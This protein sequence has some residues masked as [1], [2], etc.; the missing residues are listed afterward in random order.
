MKKTPESITRGIVAALGVLILAGT[1]ALLL[2]TV[3]SDFPFIE[4]AAGAA[5]MLVCGLFCAFLL[6]C[7]KTGVWLA[8]ILVIAFWKRLSFILLVDTAPVSDFSV[9]YDAALSAAQGDFSI[10]A[11]GRGYFWAYGY[12]IPF[13]LYEALVLRLTG[14]VFA[15]KLLNVIFMTGSCLLVY[16]LAECAGRNAALCAAFLYAVY[17]DAI[18]LSSVLTNQHIAL[19]F[20]LLGL[21]LFCREGILSAVFAGICLS[22]S[23]LMRPGAV[24]GLAAVICLSVYRIIR[25]LRKGG[26]L[27]ALLR[28][29]AAAGVY[30]ALNAAAGAILTG[31]GIAPDGISAKVPQ[32]KFIIGLDFSGSGGY[33]SDLDFI[34]SPAYTD[35]ERWAITLETISGSYQSFWQA[36]R[37]FASKCVTMWCSF[38]GP[39]WAL[40]GIDG[41]SPMLGKI[42]YDTFITFLNCS[43]IGVYLI[44]WL[45]AA[46]GAARMI[47][48]KTGDALFLALIAFIGFFL[49]YLAIEVM[50]RYRYE[51]CS[52]IAVLAA[53]GFAIFERHPLPAPGTVPDAPGD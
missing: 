17:P 23:S 34:F 30:F 9:L 6:R 19:L 50:D 10:F 11:L 35:S 3:T 52:L 4:R 16:K 28:C 13:C 46:A 25:E 48:K 24:I 33:N 31:S 49:I 22:F 38:R 12:Q 29:L 15:L 1:F 43:N 37:F 32:W 47:K 18:M 2:R 5:A 44:M 39:G 36:L 26:A 8:V 14:S 40:G 51:A 27:R 45:A 7:R 21:Y 20:L 41:S 53:G 42:T